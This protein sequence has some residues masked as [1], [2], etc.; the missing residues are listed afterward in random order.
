MPAPT[1]V[2]TLRSFLGLVSHNSTFFFPK[3]HRIRAPLNNPLK[4]VITW[5]WFDVCQSAFTQVKSLVSSNPLLTH[6]DPS[7]DIVV[8]SDASNNGFGTVIS[9]ALFVGS[10]KAT[11]HASRSLICRM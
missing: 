9:H 1:N 5:D 4:K 11:E 7:M 6:Y 3:L 10:Q 8:V 2:K